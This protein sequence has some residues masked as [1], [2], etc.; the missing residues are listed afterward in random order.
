MTKFTFIGRS[1]SGFFHRRKSK[2][3]TDIVINSDSTNDVK[4]IKIYTLEVVRRPSVII[5]CN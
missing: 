2:P 5:P 4:L 1:S 3:P